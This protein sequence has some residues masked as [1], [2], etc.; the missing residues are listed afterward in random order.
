ML[1][2]TPKSQVRLTKPRYGG[3]PEART[4]NKD[5]RLDRAQFNADHRLQLSTFYA[6]ARIQCWQQRQRNATALPLR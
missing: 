5:R 6:S 2:T 3:A 4:I 1:W